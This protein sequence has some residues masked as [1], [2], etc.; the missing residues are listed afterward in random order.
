MDGETSALFWLMPVVIVGVPVAAAIGVSLLW[1][2]LLE[3]G[4]GI[5]LEWPESL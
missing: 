5:G 2:W 3:P 4:R 1:V